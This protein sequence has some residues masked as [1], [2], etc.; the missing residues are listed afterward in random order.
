MGGTK[1]LQWTCHLIPVQMKTR[2]FSLDKAE[3]SF[4]GAVC[5]VVDQPVAKI[6]P[7]TQFSCKLALMA[8]VLF[9]E[10]ED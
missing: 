5:K 8:G 6:Q 7:G 10:D 9:D 3:I 4:F 2:C 1:H